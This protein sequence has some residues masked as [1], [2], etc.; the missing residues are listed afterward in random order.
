MPDDVQ[1][2][3]YRPLNHQ[4]E[5]RGTEQSAFRPVLVTE[6][7]IRRV[8]WFSCVVAHVKRLCTDLRNDGKIPDFPGWSEEVVCWAVV[9]SWVWLGTQISWGFPW[10]VGD[11]EASEMLADPRWMTQLWLLSYTPVFVKAVMS[12]QT[13]LCLCVW[14]RDWTGPGAVA[15]CEQPDPSGYAHA[16]MEE[17]QEAPELPVSPGHL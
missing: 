15:E 7:K 3:W 17:P 16:V 4:E 2:R 6:E 14:F 11:S 12:K 9:M 1:E 8:N 10:L 5:R 13:N